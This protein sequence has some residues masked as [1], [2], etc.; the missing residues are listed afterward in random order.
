MEGNSVFLSAKPTKG[1][2]MNFLSKAFFFTATAAI[3]PLAMWSQAGQPRKPHNP[4]QT[5]QVLSRPERTDIAEFLGEGNNG[6]PIVRTYRPDIDHRPKGLYPDK[7][8]EFEKMDGPPNVDEDLVV[9][10]PSEPPMDSLKRLKLENLNNPIHHIG[11]CISPP[12]K[13]RPPFSGD[14]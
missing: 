3:S 8:R 7:P 4:K 9:H 10:L 5:E 6:K 12:N 14:A 1:V 2:N 11:A 13:Q